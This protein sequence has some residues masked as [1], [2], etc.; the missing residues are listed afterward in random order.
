[1]CLVLAE[2]G[3]R[4]LLVHPV[5]CVQRGD[6][7]AD[8][9]HAVRD[10]HLIAVAYQRRMVALGGLHQNRH[11]PLLMRLRPDDGGAVRLYDT[12]LLGGDLLDGVAKPLHM[13][14]VD[15]ADDGRVRVQ[16][17]RRVP[18]AAHADLD[19]GNVDRRVGELP[20]GHRRQHLE[21][22]HRGAAG[23]GHLRVD[24]GDQ[25]LDL[26]PHVHEI[27]I[28]QL[29]PVDGDALVDTF[30]VR[31][32]IQAGAQ[33]IR[34]AEGLGHAG[35]RPLAVRAGDVDH[36]ERVLRMAEHV[37]HEVHPV[38]IQIRGVVLRRAA[39][40]V[41]LHVADGLVVAVRMLKRH[42]DID[43]V[44]SSMV[45]LRHSNGRPVIC[46]RQYPVSRSPPRHCDA[47]RRHDDG[48][49]HEVVTKN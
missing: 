3:D 48:V 46:R 27:V 33:P 36:T 6:L 24:D 13:I 15:R 45:P 9:R 10:L 30:Q 8:R 49:I 28:A 39:H 23:L 18:Q 44:C 41:A 32:R 35:G 4:H 5:R 43:L 26:I 25:I 21:E 37:E 42:A 38:Q 7:A 12:G 34:P 1:M 20:D 19:D 47:N 11:D 22:A 16:H 40:D 29:L 17:V 31:R 14:H 2:L